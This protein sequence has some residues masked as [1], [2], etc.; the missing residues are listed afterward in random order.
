[1]GL[2]TVELVFAVEREFDIEIPD[3]AAEKL[4]T[5]G[6]LHEFV[7]AELTRLG[8][9]DV[10]REALFE[11]LRDLICAQLGVAPEAVVPSA[12]FVEDLDAD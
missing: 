4:A 7:V 10:S 2:D 6:A 9:A 3:A 1:M 5:V 8:R 11:L 12:R